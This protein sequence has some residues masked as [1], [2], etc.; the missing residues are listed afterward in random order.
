M[1][2]LIADS[3][4]RAAASSASGGR[5][6]RHE[7]WRAAGDG[8]TLEQVVA[9]VWDDLAA[10]GLAA[11]PACGGDMQGRVGHG[12]PADCRACGSELS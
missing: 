4:S 8:S 10:R 2:T 1:S 6:R 5:L 12:L 7:R 3:T 11:C 9:G